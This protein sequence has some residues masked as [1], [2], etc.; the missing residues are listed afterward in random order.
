M[1]K[2]SMDFLGEEVTLEDDIDQLFAHLEQFEPPADFVHRV[3]DAVSRLPLP[4][5][6]SASEAR[7]DTTD[8]LIV[9]HDH[10]PPS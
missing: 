9:R 7:Q 6:Q 4:H 1:K 8:G 10:L 5:I 2:G 3:M